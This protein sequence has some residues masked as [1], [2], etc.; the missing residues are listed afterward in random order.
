[1]CLFAGILPTVSF[2]V[3]GVLCVFA[4]GIFTVAL[5]ISQSYLIAELFGKLNIKLRDDVFNFMLLI[6]FFTN[7]EELEK[8]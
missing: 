3:L 5:T 8:I 6:V 1:M 7:P 2:M 4:F